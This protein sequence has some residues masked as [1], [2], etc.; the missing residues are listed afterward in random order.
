MY[1]SINYF[2]I[3]S[4]NSLLPFIIWTNTGLV[5]VDQFGKN[6]GGIWLKYDS[7]HAGKWIWKYQLQNVFTSMWWQSQNCVH[8]PCGLLSWGVIITYT[9]GKCCRKNIEWFKLF[10]AMIGNEFNC[11]DSDRVWLRL[12]I[13]RLASSVSR[14]MENME[15]TQ[16]SN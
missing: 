13:I 4:Q 14:A 5:S 6:Y 3:A 12:F 8:D 16:V 1:V 10:R 9:P 15:Q 7:F 2:I 11:S